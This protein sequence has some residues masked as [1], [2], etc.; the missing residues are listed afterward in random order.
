M[1]ILGAGGAGKSELARELFE[2]ARLSA[3]GVGA[4][5][6]VFKRALDPVNTALAA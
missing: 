3:A 2:P 6:D 4:D 1:A 5:Q